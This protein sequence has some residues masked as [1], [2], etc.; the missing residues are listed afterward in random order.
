[1]N[2]RKHR[3]RILI[4]GVSLFLGFTTLVVSFGAASAF[5][6]SMG[7][8]IAPCVAAALYLAFC[9]FWVAPREERGFLAKLPTLVASVA[10][11]LLFV[12]LPP[13]TWG[14]PWVMVSGCLGSVAGAML[15]QKVTA[16]TQ[17]EIPTADSTNCGKRCRNYFLAG[18][19]LMAGMALAISIGVIPSVAAD[20]TR[21]SYAH[22]NAVFLGTTVVFDLLATA[23]L[24]FAVWGSREH[25]H[26]S[27]GTLGIT[28]FL[29]LLLSFIYCGM[30]VMGV[31]ANR[32]ALRIASF[33]LVLCAI[34]GLITTALMTV[35]SVIVDRARLRAAQH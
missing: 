19:T 33:L 20:T 4:T 25:D 23:L 17:G 21:G 7:E 26:P 6:N 11:L 3:S 10:P 9:Q 13:R 8:L 35:S 16:P 31:L 29:A 12:N 28:A 15:A 32:P 2:T 1:M 24:A 30:G 22:T 34:L 27:K 14:I 5:E 18:F